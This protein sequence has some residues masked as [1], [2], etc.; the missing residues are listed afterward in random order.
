M[1]ATA[2]VI[3]GRS[4]SKLAGRGG[5]NFVFNVSPHMEKSRSVKSGDRGGQAIDP[6][7]PI[8]PTIVQDWQDL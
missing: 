3:H 2:S 8:Q 7:R 6:P 5:K 1:V 4:S